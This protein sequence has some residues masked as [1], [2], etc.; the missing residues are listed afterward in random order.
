MK[1]MI[2][3]CSAGSLFCDFENK[4][5]YMK[6][7]ISIC[8][9]EDA[10]LLAYVKASSLCLAR[11]RR[12]DVTPESEIAGLI[13]V[14]E[15]VSSA[16]ESEAMQMPQALPWSLCQRKSSGHS[17]L[18]SMAYQVG[19]ACVIALLRLYVSKSKT[20]SMRSRVI[21]SIKALKEFSVKAARGRNRSLHRRSV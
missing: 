19:L 13:C 3:T 17:D 14:F 9:S 18:A 11:I 8:C 21:H 4:M 15:V 1:R 5:R 6:L 7:A 10:D 2:E 20:A 12:C 16:P